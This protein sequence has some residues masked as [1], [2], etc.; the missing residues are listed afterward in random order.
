M[1][2]SGAAG[3]NS[4][5]E[6]LAILAAMFPT[7]ASEFDADEEIT[8]YHQVVR[9]L[10]PVITS[11]LKETPTQAAPFCDL[12]NAMV[13][14]GGEQENAI[15][16]CLLEHASQVSLRKV[17]RPHLSAAAATQLLR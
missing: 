5:I 16:N 11:Y 17:I 6:L 12:V 8:T 4:P 14:A 9:R 2:T 15:D 3:I 13:P 10:T 1:K 7:F